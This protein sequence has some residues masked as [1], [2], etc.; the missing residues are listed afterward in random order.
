MFQLLTVNR[1]FSVMC[2]W[3][4]FMQLWSL[5]HVCICTFSA[6]TQTHDRFS[7]KIS[8][9]RLMNYDFRTKCD[10]I[11]QWMVWWDR[12][13]VIT[14]HFSLNIAQQMAV[15]EEQQRSVSSN[16]SIYLEN[17]THKQFKPYAD[18]SAS[19]KTQRAIKI[20]YRFW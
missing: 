15:N 7:P 20:F 2:C 8:N 3:W 10:G 18:T 17:T 14:K 9:F 1:L 13:R 4:C 12:H 19:A 11:D 16:G 5:F 6:F